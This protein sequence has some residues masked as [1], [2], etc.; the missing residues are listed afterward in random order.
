MIRGPFYTIAFLGVHVVAGAISTISA[1]S[2]NISSSMPNTILHEQYISP[3][4]IS[5][6]QS[7]NF[8]ILNK[9]SMFAWNQNSNGGVKPTDVQWCKAAVTVGTDEKHISCLLC[10]FYQA[11]FLLSFRLKRLFP[12]APA[13]HLEISHSSHI[14][15]SSKCLAE[16]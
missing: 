8:A 5:W 1:K 4:K 16:V 13:G 12:V 3:S 9:L 14:L 6:T 15:I 2:P 11:T 10:L 7:T